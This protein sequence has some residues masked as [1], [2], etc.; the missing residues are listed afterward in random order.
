MKISNR[1]KIKGTYL[2]LPDST[3]NTTISKTETAESLQRNS[4]QN[5]VA[6]KLSAARGRNR[7]NLFRKTKALSD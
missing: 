1:R 2:R 4:L 5:H 7:K 6:C 3:T